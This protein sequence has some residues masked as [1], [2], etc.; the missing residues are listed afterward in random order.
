M[1]NNSFA[2]TM[3]TN[4]AAY[5]MSRR[6]FH[7]GPGATNSMIPLTK[8]QDGPDLP[9]RKDL[10][11]T[12]QN[13]LAPLANGSDLGYISMNPVGSVF[14]TETPPLHYEACSSLKKDYNDQLYEEIPGECL[15]KEDDDNV[16][17][18][19]ISSQFQLYPGDVEYGNISADGKNPNT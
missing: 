1:F 16:R 4:N 10:Y 7:W 3:G 13:V 18:G 17:Y 19:N 14:I 9:P 11:M 8:F 6:E 5:G 15:M 2:T 12:P